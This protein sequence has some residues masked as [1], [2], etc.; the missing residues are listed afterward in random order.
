MIQIAGLIIVGIAVFWYWVLRPGRL[1]FWRLVAKHPDAAYDHFMSNACWKVFEDGLPQDYRSTVP[2]S[3]W[4]GPFRVDVPKRGD[5]T[6]KVFG[7]RSE[8]EKSQNDLLNKVAHL[9]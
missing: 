2:R 8:L 6:I 5:K 9:R 4:A 3:E 1:G 7:R